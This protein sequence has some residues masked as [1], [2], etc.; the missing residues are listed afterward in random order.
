[1]AR[2]LVRRGPFQ[3]SAKNVLRNTDKRRKRSVIE[4]VRKGITGIEISIFAC[5]LGHLQRTA[6]I[7][8]IP[9]EIVATDQARLIAWYATVKVFAG[10]IVRRPGLEHASRRT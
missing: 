6:V 9:G 10:R 7:D 2:I 1:M 5:R 8:R 4:R 3:P